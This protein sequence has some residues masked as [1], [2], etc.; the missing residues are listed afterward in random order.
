MD[1]GIPTEEVLGEMRASG[2]VNLLEVEAAFKRLKD[3]LAIRPI[4]H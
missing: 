4:Y 3:D 2:W 1:R